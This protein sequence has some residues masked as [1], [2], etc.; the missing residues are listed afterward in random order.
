MYSSRFDTL[1]CLLLK[2][3]RRREDPRR[4]QGGFDVD[5]YGSCSSFKVKVDR[6]LLGSVDRGW[7][8][9]NWSAL[10]ITPPAFESRGCY[11]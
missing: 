7:Y 6:L 1:Y 2:R 5:L 8:R 9:M 10:G 4:L 11:Y 3:R